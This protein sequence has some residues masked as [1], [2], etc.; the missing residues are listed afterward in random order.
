MFSRVIAAVARKKP[1][2]FVF[3]E[4]NFGYLKR[5]TDALSVSE[6]RPWYNSKIKF[7]HLYAF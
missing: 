4:L 5:K 7:R 3:A 2:L 6:V 1:L